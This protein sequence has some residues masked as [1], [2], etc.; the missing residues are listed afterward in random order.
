MNNL[1]KFIT[2]NSNELITTFL[3]ERKTHNEIGALFIN[4]DKNT[5]NVY[6]LNINMINDPK[7]KQNIIDRNKISTNK[8]LF[9]CYDKDSSE[10]VE[11]NI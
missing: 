8:V 4:L 1:E 11:I 6:Y 7:I 5:D 2:H 3:N 9:Y 10:L